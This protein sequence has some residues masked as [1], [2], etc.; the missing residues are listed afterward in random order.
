MSCESSIKSRSIEA[1]FFHRSQ[2]R[3]SPFRLADPTK[4]GHRRL[5]ALW[6]VDPHKR[7]IS[8]ANVPPQQ[9][10]WC[11][12]A[13]LGS[14]SGLHEEALSRLPPG[15]VDLLKEKSAALGSSTINATLS[16]KLFDLVKEHL[17]VD[18]HA[19]PMS[20]EEAKQHRLK[21]MQE[22]SAHKRTAEDWWQQH[23]YGFCEH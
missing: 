2:H 7:I 17:S 16:Q 13:I 3:V 23:S 8:T 10:S 21:L 12:E 14:T 4:P 6:L 20:I 1:D 9:M 22:R 11:F 5:I 15:F 19:V 18:R